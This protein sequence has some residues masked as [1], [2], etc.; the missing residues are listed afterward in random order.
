MGY[1]DYR[2][3]MG[4]M[5]RKR[6]TPC[7]CLRCEALDRNPIVLD[8]NPIAPD[9]NPIVLD[10]NPI[11]LGRNPTVCTSSVRP[12]SALRRNPCYA[13]GVMVI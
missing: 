13:V 7:Q 12:A 9:R 10:R 8:R 4:Y 11:V 6:G 3:Y 1:R 2:G 5:G